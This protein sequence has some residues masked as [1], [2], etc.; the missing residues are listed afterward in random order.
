M[1]Q[2]KKLLGLT[3]VVLLAACTDNSLTNP[4]QDAVG[5]YDLTVY[6]GASIPANYTISPGDPN[7]P[8]A[9]NGGTLTVTDGQLIL[10]QNGTFNEINNYVITPTGGS[11]V[12]RSFVSNGTWTIQNNTTIFLNAPAQN[13]FGPRSVQGTI[14]VDTIRYQE[15]NGS[16]GFDAFEYRR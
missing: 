11:A 2:T 7:F 1:R 6:A 13:G 8:E 15:E 12:N 4:F 10:N 5:S 14:D 16:G 3:A 9:P